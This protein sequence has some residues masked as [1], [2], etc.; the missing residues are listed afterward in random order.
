MPPQ[1]KSTLSATSTLPPPPP[2]NLRPRPSPHPQSPLAAHCAR[3]LT[4][5]VL[6][7]V[8]RGAD[9]DPL[10]SSS[11]GLARL[12]LSLLAL[13]LGPGSVGGV[14]GLGGALRSVVLRVSVEGGLMRG[15]RGVGAKEGIVVGFVRGVSGWPSCVPVEVRGGVEGV[16]GRG[17]LE[18]VAVVCAFGGFYGVVSAL[19]GLA[20]VA[21]GDEEAGRLARLSING[22]GEFAVRG[23][24]GKQ[25]LLARITAPLKIMGA[26]RRVR[27]MEEST[28]LHSIPV[29]KRS[30][31]GYMRAAMGFMPEYLRK[32]RSSA[33]RRVLILAIDTI[34]L[35][36][37]MDAED[38]IPV[39]VRNL[40]CYILAKSAES[41]VL[42]AHSAFVAHHFGASE[43]QLEAAMDLDL[44]LSLRKAYSLSSTSAASSLSMS[45][46]ESPSPSPPE[47]PLPTPKRMRHGWADRGSDS[48]GAGFVP[49]AHEGSDANNA[50][51]LNGDRAQG[52]QRSEPDE[53]QLAM[54]SVPEDSHV[55]EPSSIDSTR[56]PFVD[57]PEQ[58]QM[59]ADALGGS[60]IGSGNES[61]GSEGE[62]YDDAHDAMDEDEIRADKLNDEGINRDENDGRDY[63]DESDHGDDDDDDDE[64]DEG[65]EVD[66]EYAAFTQRADRRERQPYGRQRP[67]SLADKKSSGVAPFTEREVT[68]LLLA[69][70]V[71]RTT[72]RRARTRERSSTGLPQ[73]MVSENDCATMR[74]L[75]SSEG[76]MEATSV[77]GVFFLLQRWTSI[78]HPRPGAFESP[79]RRFVQS[80][81]GINLDVGAVGQRQSSRVDFGFG[82]S[83]SASLPISLP[84]E[85]LYF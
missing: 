10:L 30:Q 66:A 24:V 77:I 42:T 18:H 8:P 27:Q 21:E 84:R 70:S 85:R 33:V 71:A 67:R 79:V 64:G 29:S 11:L 39:P 61:Y 7:P 55:E 41:S 20:D 34:L 78:Y 32:I 40:M 82:L 69:H 13:V 50:D 83:S 23:N 1:R 53:Y 22:E 49:G 17:G 65:D 75:F 31:T 38:S 63:D 35:T 4:R 73:R 52:K 25:G 44:L 80:Y 15:V 47:K 9:L 60:E 16:L 14:R 48:L 6:A 5:H 36:D 76:I 3:R 19:V 59:Y 28:W 58:L 12:H 43:Y 45:S 68:L 26:A 51:V 72:R 37:G 62:G 46:A 57:V 2:P 74:R 81:I 56:M 54:P